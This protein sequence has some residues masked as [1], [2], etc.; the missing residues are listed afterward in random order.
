MRL[1]ERGRNGVLP[2]TC[3]SDVESNQNARGAR[4]KAAVSFWPWAVL[5][6]LT[7]KERSANTLQPEALYVGAVT[8]GTGFSFF[9]HGGCVMWLKNC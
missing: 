3:E 7:P 2:I 9:L 6:R 4:C 5:S 1:V 8:L